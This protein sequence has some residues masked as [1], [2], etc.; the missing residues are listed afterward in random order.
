M[1]FVY[2]MKSIIEARTILFMRNYL[3]N[4]VRQGWMI[5]AILF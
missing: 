2:K 5:C 1:V 3:F 4:F